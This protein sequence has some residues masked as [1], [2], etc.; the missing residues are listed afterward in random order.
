MVELRTGSV[1]FVTVVVV[2]ASGGVGVAAANAAIPAAAS[3]DQV[4]DAPPS[5][6][7]LQ[8]DGTTDSND[9]RQHRNPRQYDE[10]GDL[11]GLENR[12]ATRLAQSLETGAISLED[13]EY[14]A[15]AAS[16]DEAYAADL[17]R[18]ADVADATAGEDYG[19]L[20]ELAGENQARLVEAVR[21]YNATR[22]EYE[23]AR[24]I[25]DD[26]RARA[27]ARELESLA[28]T[29]NES[30]SEL[31]AT[32]D[33]LER[34]TNANLSESDAAVESVA[35]EIRREQAAIREAEFVTTELTVEAE[36][37]QISFREPLTATGQLRT[38]DGR[39][40]GSET[41][42]LEI[43]NGS[44]RTET[45]ADGSFSV[46][47]RPTTESLSTDRLNVEYVPINESIYLGS[48]TSVPVSISQ[49]EPTV[50]NLETP[51]T[52]AYDE[53]TTVRGNLLVGET[54]VDGVPL[55][56]TLGDKRIATVETSNGF[57]ETDVTVPASVADGDREL[58]VRFDRE[59][60]ALAAMTATNDVTVR[61]TSTDVTI[62]AT[63]VGDDERTVAVDGTLETVNGSAIAGRSIRLNAGDT[64]I[65]TVTTGDDG[66]YAT[67]IEIPATAGRDVR[68]V[69]A[70][71]GS[72]S[73]LES[74]T[75]ASTVSFSSGSRA[76]SG[77]PAW[78]WLGFGGGVAAFAALVAFAW[79]SRARS[80]DRES[81][82]AP[83]D[84]TADRGTTPGDGRSRPEIARSVLEHGHDALSSGR[85]D[86][87]VELGYAAVRH[88][89]T[90]AV[91]S[92][93]TSTA[94][95][96]WEFYRRWADRRDDGADDSDADLLRTV[97]ERYER[98]TFDVA[99]V[100]AAEAERVLE[101]GRRLCDRYADG[102]DARS[103]VDDE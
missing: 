17:A 103:A 81:A 60:R 73:N 97:T 35:A 75:A 72:G 90:G 16:V 2:L 64:T 89:L 25:G 10:S 27:L 100:S 76:W 82:T 11:T 67:T 70:Y 86:R 68:V 54:P 47:Y 30:S 32:Y 49:V 78:A 85:P 24:A 13:G 36:R 94:L 26:E 58:G 15:A 38:A 87:A 92:S 74:E 80:S 39:P 102:D 50:S 48:E 43:G 42:R 101:V 22:S 56:V 79:R 53:N 99:T 59:G 95:T 41:I 6:L 20:F 5:R 93:T 61:E 9:T 37:E 23:R 44:V 34:S 84:G 65:E 77:L 21:Q 33:G 19:D 1:V 28:G 7:A 12:L 29:V 18:Y 63:R 4:G 46:T 57:F 14:A 31:Q 88:A 55:A 71:D 69:A 98:A 96:H 83:G 3:P 66:S 40:V 52:V 51:D 8:S 62:S 45:A 91:D